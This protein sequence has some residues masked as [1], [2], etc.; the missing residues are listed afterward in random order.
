MEPFMPWMECCVLAICL[1]SHVEQWYGTMSLYL[2]EA[3]Q[4]RLLWNQLCC[5]L[6]RWTL[7]NCQLI[8]VLCSHRVFS[9]L[10]MHLSSANKVMNAFRH[11]GIF[12]VN[13]HAHPCRHAS[14]LQASN[15]YMIKNDS[16]NIKSSVYVDCVSLSNILVCRIYL[17]PHWWPRITKRVKLLG[18]I[19]I[20]WKSGLHYQTVCVALLDACIQLHH[21][22][23]NPW[24]E[25][26]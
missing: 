9:E 26:L 11:I 10:Y 1:A 18:F 13:L 21:N 24:C 23:W 4:G 5:H 22:I 8:L 3:P 6:Y 17:R 12:S 19:T 2:R 20:I 14:L 7:A 15:H 16:I 25:C